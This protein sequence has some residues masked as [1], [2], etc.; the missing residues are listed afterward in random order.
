VSGPILEPIWVRYAIWPGGR[1][2][3]V[4]ALLQSE[5]GIRVPL[6]WTTEQE[7]GRVAEW[8]PYQYGMLGRR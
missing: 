4:E 3:A 6:L 8:W 2:S 5:D 1:C 7:T